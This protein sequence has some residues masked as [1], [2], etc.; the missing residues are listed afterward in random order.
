MKKYN[1]NGAVKDD[2]D[3]RDILSSY[4]L[5][6]YEVLP[7]KIVTDMTG[8]P[9]WDQGAHGSCVPHCGWKIK[10]ALHYW[11]TGELIDFEPGFAYSLDKQMD[12]YPNT[13]GTQPR[14]DDSNASKYGCAT[15]ST[16]KL[17]A[18][19]SYSD[20]ITFPRTDELLRDAIKNKQGISYLQVLPTIN[21]MKQALIS[22]K[23]LRVSLRCGSEWFSPNGALPNF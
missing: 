21:A 17:N 1:T 5:P 18:Y 10:Q 2:K 4:V 13:E 16:L 3:Y 22:C 6:R 20:Y 8:I 12:G 7:S 23:L 11:K 9:H 19:G 14:I 15:K